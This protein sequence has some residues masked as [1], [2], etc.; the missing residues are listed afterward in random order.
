MIEGS[1][2]FGPA[3]RPMTGYLALPA[4]WHASPDVA[5]S[6][7][8]RALAHVGSMPPKVKKPKPMNLNAQVVKRLSPRN[9][10]SL[11]VIAISASAAAC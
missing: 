10:P 3:E 4:A 1:G 11:P 6:W 8:E 9:C 5:A 7:V 2:L